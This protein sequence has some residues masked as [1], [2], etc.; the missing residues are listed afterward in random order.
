MMNASIFMMGT[1][2]SLKTIPSVGMQILRHIIRW[3]IFT[4]TPQVQPLSLSNEISLQI[5]RWLLIIM[6]YTYVLGKTMMPVAQSTFRTISSATSLQ[7]NII[8]S[9]HC[10]SI[11]W[12]KTLHCWYLL[13]SACFTGSICELYFES[14]ASPVNVANTF[15]SNLQATSSSCPSS[16]CI[17]KWPSS[18]GSGYCSLNG[19]I[20]NF[21]AP[22]GQYHLA[23][24]TD[25][26]PVPLLDASLSYFGTIDESNLTSYIFD[27]RDDLEY[28]TVMYLPYLLTND[29]DGGR[30]WVSIHYIWFTC[31]LHEPYIGSNICIAHIQTLST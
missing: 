26:D 20:F 4:A 17:S 15:E 18:C 3:H 11:C 29:P 1:K 9:W 2:Q 22:E 14:A 28:S 30:R 8:F 24:Y 23:I 12:D 31:M 5:G 7:V 21:P 27:G 16:L 19:N 13:C 6:Q 25:A 10:M